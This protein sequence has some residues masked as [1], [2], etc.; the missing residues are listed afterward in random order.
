MVVRFAIRNPNLNSDNGRAKS[1]SRSGN[2][3]RGKGFVWSRIES[4]KPRRSAFGYVYPAVDYQQMCA[5]P[6]TSTKSTGQNSTTKETRL[7]SLGDVVRG[8]QHVLTCPHF[9]SADEN[10]SIEFDSAVISN[11]Y[12]QNFQQHAILP[13]SGFQVMILLFLYDKRGRESKSEDSE[14]GHN[15]DDDNN[16]D[17]DEDGDEEGKGS[18]WPNGMLAEHHRGMLCNQCLAGSVTVPSRSTHLGDGFEAEEKG[19]STISELADIRK[20]EVLVFKPTNLSKLADATLTTNMHSDVPVDYMTRNRNSK[21][22][23]CKGILKDM[24]EFCH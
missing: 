5:S 23:E 17:G 10:R 12:A 11:R 4:D 21:R 18:A 14:G 2:T 8:L 9:I 22:S 20:E 1:V 24:E 13:L 16:D 6:S 7:D 3:D 19:C 15:D